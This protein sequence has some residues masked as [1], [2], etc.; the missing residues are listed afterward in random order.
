VFHAWSYHWFVHHEIKTLSLLTGNYIPIFM[1]RN[2]S[3]IKLQCPND[4]YVWFYQG[5][6]DVTSCPS[7][8]WRVRVNAP[9]RI[10]TPASD[11]LI[12]ERRGERLI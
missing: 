4:G 3:G 9:Q 6:K 1:P 11:A 10:N 7:C 5:D 8:G 2:T 12:T